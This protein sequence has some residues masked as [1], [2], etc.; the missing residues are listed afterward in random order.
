[1][2]SEGPNPRRQQQY[3]S[4]CV[5]GIS[6]R[7]II[8]E[9]MEDHLL[10]PHAGP[11]PGTSPNGLETLCEKEFGGRHNPVQLK[12]LTHACART[13]TYT[14]TLTHTGKHAHTRA[15]HRT[16]ARVR[17]AGSKL[18]ALVRSLPPPPLGCSRGNTGRHWRGNSEVLGSGEGWMGPAFSPPQVLG[19]AQ[20][21]LD[22]GD[23]N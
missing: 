1:M 3:R 15:H 12:S 11:Q 23:P 10:R 7:N 2:A 8:T 22:Q 4:S 5:R 20:R 6:V 21:P 14:R 19:A 9:Q 18:C 13:H 17:A 16:Q